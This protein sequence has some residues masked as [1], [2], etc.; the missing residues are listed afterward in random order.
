MYK[1]KTNGVNIRS[2][3]EWY[4]FGE[5]IFLNL[6]KQ[7]PLQSQELTRTLLCG[8]KDRSDR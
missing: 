3:C 7:H 5:R 8:E 6:E 1:E 2:K 4:E